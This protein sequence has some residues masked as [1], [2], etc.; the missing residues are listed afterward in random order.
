MTTI[1]EKL[2]QYIA[3]HE[4]IICCNEG[5]TLCSSC[6]FDVID[7]GFSRCLACNMPTLDY[8][9][10]T[11]CIK[12]SPLSH[13]FILGSYEDEL[14]QLVRLLK[15]EHVR[16]IATDIIEAWQ[17]ILPLFPKHVVV[18]YVPTSARRQR[19]RGFDQAA[20]L[21]KA[22]A[23]RKSLSYQSLLTRKGSTKQ[24]G[25]SRRQRFLQANV[26]FELNAS[27]SLKD[28]TII[29][30]D[31]VI[32]TG[33]TVNAVATK[34]RKAGAKQIIAVAIARQKLTQ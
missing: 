14:K 25:A 32:T 10:C 24:V 5:Y 28:K 29:L 9:I 16:Q 4:C 27:V 3:P 11:W 19:E 15:Y 20:L 6:V 23:K 30:V 21:A 22:L 12:K 8:A 17:A 33:A 31:D 26:M 34:L 7:E 2:L 13:A 1:L 18:T